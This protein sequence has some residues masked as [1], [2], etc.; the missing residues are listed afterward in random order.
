[1]ALLVLSCQMLMEVDIDFTSL[2]FLF[3]GVDLG[4]FGGGFWVRSFHRGFVIV[5]QEF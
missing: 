3:G 4:V 5:V 2:L 1:M